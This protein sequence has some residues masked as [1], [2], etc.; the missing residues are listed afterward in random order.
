[1]EQLLTL[2]EVCLL[3]KIARATAYRMMARGELPKPITISLRARRW[4]SS[5]IETLMNKGRE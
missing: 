4:R 1:M 3:L 2:L 5:E